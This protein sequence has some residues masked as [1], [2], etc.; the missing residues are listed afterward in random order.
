VADLKKIGELRHRITFQQQ[1]HTSDGQG[2]TEIVWQDVKTVWASVLPKSGGQFFFAERVE[3]RTTD[4]VIVRD[5]GTQINEDMRIKFGQRYLQIQSI[6]R[7][8][9]SKRFFQKID[10]TDKVGT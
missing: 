2:G 8:E 10:T 5:L 6:D 3:A 9:N 4:V 7:F 1:I